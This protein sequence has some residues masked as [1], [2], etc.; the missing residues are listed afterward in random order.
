MGYSGGKMKPTDKRTLFPFGA[1]TAEG[2]LEL[3]SG[4]GVELR[5]DGEKLNARTK[6]PVPERA[7]KLIRENRDMLYQHLSG[8]SETKKAEAL[9][10]LPPVEFDQGETVVMREV[11]LLRM[12]DGEYLAITT[13]EASTLDGTAKEKRDDGKQCAKQPQPESAGLF[14]SRPKRKTSSTTSQ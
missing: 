11:V 12:F 2:L 9:A 14:S 6:G 10:K 8:E 4:M 1:N 3:L 13:E 5:L 7:A